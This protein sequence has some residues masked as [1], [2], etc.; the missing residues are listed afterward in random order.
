MTDRT[1]NGTPPSPGGSRGRVNAATNTALNPT[2]S[3]AYNDFRPTAEISTPA[4]AGPRIRPACWVIPDRADALASC[5]L[6]TIPAMIE[7]RAGLLTAWNPEAAATQTNSAAIVGRP[8]AVFKYSP[9]L[10][11]AR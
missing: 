6:D 11:I 9:M 2:A 3:M 4:S 7:P 8:S 1:P 10:V 5:S